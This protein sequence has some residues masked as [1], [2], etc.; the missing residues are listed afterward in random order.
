MSCFG[1]V[2]VKKGLI[3]ALRRRGFWK[4]DGIANFALMI[5]HLAFR[6]VDAGKFPE[7]FD[8]I[9]LSFGE[10]AEGHKESVFQRGE[11]EV[12]L[13]ENLLGAHELFVK[14]IERKLGGEDGV[15]HVEEAVIARGKVS[16]LGDPGLRSRIWRVDGDVNDLG[17]LQRPF[18]DGFEVALVPIG[19]GDDVYG[20]VNVQRSGAFEGFD[21]LFYGDALAVALEALVI[22]SFDTEKHIFQDEALPHFENFFVAYEDIAQ[23]RHELTLRYPG[24]WRDFR[25]PLLHC[26]CGSCRRKT[27]R[28]CRSNTP[29]G[30][31]A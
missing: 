6:V 10:E 21:I 26:A 9:R 18:A 1:R 11:T 29:T 28:R 17:D 4:A 20:G 5:L 23:R 8:E 30:N 7:H 24:S 13:V 19:I 3:H 27:S 25:Q 12:L 22:D 14:A 16:R 31:R 2:D 15:L